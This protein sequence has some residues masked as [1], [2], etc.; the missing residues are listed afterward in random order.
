[1]E[2]IA[3]L[4]SASL[5]LLWRSYPGAW[6]TPEAVGRSAHRSLDSTHLPFTALSKS[7]VPP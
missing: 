5:S 3:H 1:L 2:D 4:I 6:I 7:F